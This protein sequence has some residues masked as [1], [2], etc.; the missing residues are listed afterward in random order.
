MR[1]KFREELYTFIDVLLDEMLN[2]NCNY[3]AG[4]INFEYRTASRL[5]I[6][7][8]RNKIKDRK[9]TYESQIQRSV[10]E[11]AGTNY[12]AKLAYDFLSDLSAYIEE[13]LNG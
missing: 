5:V 2:R 4:T 3:F 1:D 9:I 6:L 10:F 13:K 7:H 11:Q 8:Y 12:S